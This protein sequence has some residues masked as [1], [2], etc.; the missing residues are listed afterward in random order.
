MVEGTP[1]AHVHA[2]TSNT[3]T[4]NVAPN[5]NTSDDPGIINSPHR[6]ELLRFASPHTKHTESHTSTHGH[7]HCQK[8][9]S[10]DR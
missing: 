6:K 10:R 8:W 4:P 9:D 1:H 2:H 7:T 5:N 3:Q